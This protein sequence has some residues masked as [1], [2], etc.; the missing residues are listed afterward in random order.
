MIEIGLFVNSVQAIDT[1]INIFEDKIGIPPYRRYK[2]G[3][4]EYYLPFLHITIIPVE[5]TRGQKYDLIYYDEENISDEMMD[6]IY[7]CCLYS[8]PRPLKYFLNYKIS[9]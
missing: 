3:Y 1:L 6:I 9:L 5:F 4:A 8:K 7:P 2:Q